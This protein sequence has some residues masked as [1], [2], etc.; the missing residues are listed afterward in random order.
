MCEWVDQHLICDP[1]DLQVMPR[2]DSGSPSLAWAFNRYFSKGRF[3]LLAGIIFLC[4][5]W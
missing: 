2:G 3:S 5:S 4:P 1:T